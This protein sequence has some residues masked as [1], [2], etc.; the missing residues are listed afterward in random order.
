MKKLYYLLL[1]AFSLINIQ[2]KA[3]APF[4]TLDYVDINNI[5]ASVLV[6]GDLFW[7]PALM[8]ADCHFPASA[9]T[10]INFVSALWMSGYDGS[11]Q[12]HVAA[13]TYRQMGNDYWPG[14]LD[15]SDT[16]TYATSRDWAKIWK[17]NRKDIAMFI[18]LPTHTTTNT[19]PMILTW[20]GKGNANATGNGGAPLTITNDMAPFTDLNHN[21]IYEPLLGEYPDIPGDQALW[22][23]FSDNGPAHT[24][25][26]G[27]PLGVEIH[28]MAYAYRRG[29]LIDNVIYYDYK[30]T[31]KSANNYANFRMG[32]FDDVDLGYSFDDYIGF[33]SAHRMGIT[34]NGINDDGSSAGH[35]ANSYGTSIPIVGVSMIILP[36]DNL[37]TH[38]HVPAGSFMYYNNDASPYGNPTSGPEYDNYLRSKFRSGTHLTND[39]TGAG[40][41]STGWG[42]GPLTDYVYSGDPAVSTEWSE[43]A[44]NNNLGDRRFI[45]T[46]NDF[47]MN[48]GSTQEV[49]MALLTTPQST[50]NACPLAGFSGIKDVADTAWNTFYN[51]LPPSPTLGSKNTW[52]D[53]HLAIFPNPAHDQLNIEGIQNSNI[54]VNIY[55]VLGQKM[56]VGFDRSNNKVVVDVSNL[57]AGVYHIT[58][59]DGVTQKIVKFV[60]E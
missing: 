46:S 11:S 32:L 5:K 21:G 6:H 8:E 53:K 35:P 20:P 58:Y 44:S 12:L 39:F 55:D 13:Q 9:P 4:N 24:E 28:A 54:S 23:V 25:T 60:K 41:P 15:A 36:G 27:K 31:N 19:P 10:N 49:V 48:S 33:D 16:L 43:C 1:P 17:V 57:A 37:T 26:N 42:A 51:P 40:V 3:Q 30:I 2:A 52:A 29:T 7:D 38:T 50:S 56:N 47:A 14:P 18:A 22:W 45:I 34:Y 59:N